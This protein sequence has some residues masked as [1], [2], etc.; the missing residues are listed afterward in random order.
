MTV[1]SEKIIWHMLSGYRT[2]SK[3][4]LVHILTQARKAYAQNRPYHIVATY[5]ETYR[6]DHRNLYT[7]FPDLK[8]FI[9]AYQYNP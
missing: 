1:S 6:K 2:V 4:S 5:G 3:G 9:D 7:Y 8:S